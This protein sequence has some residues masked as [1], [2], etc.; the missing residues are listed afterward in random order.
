MNLLTRTLKYT[1]IALVAAA[2]GVG[3]TSALGQDIK[4]D[5][6]DKKATYKDKNKEQFCSN[7]HWS[8]DDKVSFKELRET[9]IAAAGTITVDAGRNGGVSVIGEDRNDVLVRVCIQ[10][11]GTD[12]AAA[13]T[14]AGTIKINTTGTIKA[15]GPSEEKNWGVSFQLRVPKSSNLQLNAKNGGISIVDVDGDVE[16]ETVNGGINLKNLAGDVRG[17]T[18]NGGLN[19][20]L[21]GNSWKGS[22]LDVT[23]TNG[24]VNLILSD[25]YAA[26]IETGTVNGGFIS[27]IPAL[28]VT[29]EDYKGGYGPRTKRI[30]TNL[31]GGGAPIKVITTNGGV[32][33]NSADK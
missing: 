4:S 21:A 2:I 20:I 22:G 16:F 15:G 31:N 28:S 32:R 17:R 13:K 30:S 8:S 6:K 18:T 7:N 12:E 3:A 33:I 1:A 26:H 27:E 11:W 29:T 19:V 14:L 5:G 23:T 10:A 9:T 24:G 25:N